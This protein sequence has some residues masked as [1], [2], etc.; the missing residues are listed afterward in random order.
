MCS[1][2]LPFI[3]KAAL[4]WQKK[5]FHPKGSVG[6]LLTIQQVYKLTNQKHRN[7]YIYKGRTC[8]PE[9]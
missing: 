3:A 6:N 7:S 8:V 5:S 9:K 2:M 4:L 1:S